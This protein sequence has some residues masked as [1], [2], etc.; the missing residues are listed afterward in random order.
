VNRSSGVETLNG[1]DQYFEQHGEGRPLLLLHGFTGSGADWQYVF[2]EAE[3]PVGFRVIRPDLRGHGRSTNPEGL[4][5]FGQVARD[6]FGLLDRLGI[7]RFQAIGMSAG[8]KTL[9]HM[10]TQQPAR[11]DSMVLVSA[12]PYFPDSARAIMAQSTDENQ[13]ADDWRQMRERHP[14]GDE[15][16][17]ELWRIA[18]SFAQ[19]YEDMNFTPPLLSTIRARTLIVH[20]DRDPL[21][22]VELA[23]GMFDAIPDSALSVVAGGGHGPIFGE[24]AAPFRESALA[25]LRDAPSDR[26]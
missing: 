12:A 8:A 2:A 13:S 20:G 9:L 25:F 15:Q 11:I 3:A 1:I 16:I 10:A 18:R 6:M 17:R 26:T 19:S 24:L 5:S 22:P 23:L 4:W 14:R 21:Y 7:E